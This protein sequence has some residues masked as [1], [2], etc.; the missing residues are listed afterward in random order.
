MLPLT[1][2]GIVMG[3]IFIRSRNLLASMPLH[4][5]YNGFVFLHLVS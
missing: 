5:R 3:I 1:F 2:L 4:G